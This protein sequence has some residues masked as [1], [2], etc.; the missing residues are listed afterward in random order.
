LNVT[1]VSSVYFLG[2]GGIGMSALA[3]WFHAN[4]CF[5][6]GYDR[7]PTS[8]T[9]HLQQE[10]IQVHFEDETGLIPPVFLKKSEKNL[11]IYT[12]AIPK[13]HREFNFF[14]DNGYE[15]KK[16]SQVLGLLTENMFTLAIAGTHGKTT[17]SSMVAHILK[18]SGKNCAAFLGGITSNY[19]TNVLLNN[20]ASA[21]APMVVV[22]ADEYDRSFLTL[23]P[24]IAII[25]SVDPDHLDIY[26]DADSVV[27]SYQQFINQ[28]K[29]G[30]SL[31]IKKGLPL[32]AP[33]DISVRVF[34]FSRTQPAYFRAE[35]VHIT[36]GD[37]VFDFIGADTDLKEVRLQVP[38]FHNVENALA[39]MA[40]SIK[41]GVTPEQAKQAIGTYKGVKR[42]FEYIVKS[43]Y[44]VYIDDYA[45]HP[46][47]IEA[48]LRSVR[49]LYPAKKITAVF[50]PHLYSR[51]RDFAEGFAS[52][53]SLADQV[54]L[55]D[56]YP[57]R[58]LPIPGVSS[59]MLLDKITSG[60]KMICGKNNLLEELNK[61]AI[62]V[63]VTIGAGD[64]DQLVL[65][66]KEY[67]NNKLSVN[68]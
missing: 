19:N 42:R 47:E 54:I 27:S 25:N 18:A 52:S 51:T 8:L 31:F 9:S 50:Q 62:E 7:T 33:K 57:A 35:N 45:H 40:A 66:I 3:R 37:F 26:G 48:L 12:P 49:A 1:H 58:E 28:I 10:G 2:I 60:E 20:T 53:L 61:M 24:D 11:I 63:L 21:D 36:E 65:P 67:F 68:Q 6:A 41:A 39:A 17:T 22:E 34:D 32:A 14:I 56:I 15:L 59:Q 55:L 4:G 64:I 43:P 44:L 5:V 38:G 23:F 30:G 13:N 16:R 46:A 29:P